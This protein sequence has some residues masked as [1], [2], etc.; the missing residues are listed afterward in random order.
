[1][2]PTDFHIFQRGRAQPPTRKSWPSPSGPGRNGPTFCLSPFQSL[3]RC[4]WWWRCGKCCLGAMEFS[5]TSVAKHRC[6]KFHWLIDFFEGFVCPSN[7]GKTMIVC[8]PNWPRP[9]FTERT[10][11]HCYAFCWKFVSFDDFTNTEQNWSQRFLLTTK[12]LSTK[13]RVWMFNGRNSREP[14]QYIFES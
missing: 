4:S 2:F 13:E 14:I 11:F 8:T 6:H 12:S 7:N 5:G 10:W 3:W 9:I 1:M